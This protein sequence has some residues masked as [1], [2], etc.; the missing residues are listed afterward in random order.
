MECLLHLKIK[1]V[2]SRQGK[3]HRDKDR[4]KV[5]RNKVSRAQNKQRKREAKLQIE[6]KETQAVENQKDRLYFN[7]QAIEAVF[8]IFFRI[9]KSIRCSKVLFWEG[10]IENNAISSFYRQH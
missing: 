7:S 9:L 2:E 1:Q 3:D 5:D 8:G 10:F 4:N 6:L